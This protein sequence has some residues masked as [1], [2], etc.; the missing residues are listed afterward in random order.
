M[1]FGLLLTILLTLALSSPF[2]VKY[3]ISNNKK[4]KAKNGVVVDD[5]ISQQQYLNNVTVPI[6]VKPLHYSKKISKKVD[7]CYIMFFVD[8]RYN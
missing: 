1:P 6:I 7:D 3:I 8:Y 4:R 5:N 2:V